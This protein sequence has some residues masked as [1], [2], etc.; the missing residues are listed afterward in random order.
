MSTTSTIYLGNADTSDVL[1]DELKRARL[2]PKELAP[3]VVAATGV[4]QPVFAQQMLQAATLCTG[5][6]IDALARAI[7]DVAVVAGASIGDANIDVMVPDVVRL[8]SDTKRD[9]DLSPHAVKLST[10]IAAVFAGRRDKGRLPAPTKHVLRA[11]LMVTGT[12]WSAWACV[13]DAPTSTSALSSWPSTF[14]G[15]RPVPHEAARDAPSSA[16]RKVTEALAWLQTSIAAT[17]VVLDLGAAPGGWSR[18]MLD[19]GATVVAVDRGDMDASLMKN[20]RLSHVRRDAYA[21]MR[22]ASRPAA[23]V[24]LCDVIAA[25][26]MTVGLIDIVAADERI[27]AAILT[28]KLTRPVPWSVLDDAR[29]RLSRY[30]L[31]G[32][33]QQLVANK[34]ECSVLM[35]R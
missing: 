2:K 7:A 32:R 35:R 4:M 1:V 29:R 23:T 31:S 28:L 9:S 20:P 25:P 24:L 11:L 15:G 14:R 21:L 34:L 22:E 3:G 26:A 27:R 17:D 12:S 5:R 33:V 19:A 18:V 30:K 10:T 8:G 13:V 16:H 6:D